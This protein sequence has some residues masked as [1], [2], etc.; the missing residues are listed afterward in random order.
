[1][2]FTVK[3]SNEN[4]YH[5]FDETQT[6]S[7]EYFRRNDPIQNSFQDQGNCLG[8][9]TKHQ[10]RKSS[11]LTCKSHETFGFLKNNCI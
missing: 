8:L 5:K 11:D 2:H 10:G 3:T 9:E 1:M 7:T 6:K 4:I